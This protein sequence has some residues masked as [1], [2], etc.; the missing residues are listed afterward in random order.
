M[1]VGSDRVSSDLT[2]LTC[3]PI[4]MSLDRV[5]RRL[6]CIEVSLLCI[7]L[8]PV[9]VVMVLLVHRWS[10]VLCNAIRTSLVSCETCVRW[11]SGLSRCCTL[12]SRLLSCDRPALAPVNPCSVCLPCP[13]RPRTFVVLLTNVWRLSGLV[14]RTVLSCF[15][16]MT[17]RTRRLSLAL[18]NSLRTLSRW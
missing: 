9:T 8:C 12:S 13:W 5:V 15:R 3:I 18:S 2:R 1:S 6:R 16:L 4:W 11:L 7:V 10:R 14:S 17:M